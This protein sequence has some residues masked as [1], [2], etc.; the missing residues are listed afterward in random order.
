MYSYVTSTFCSRLRFFT[1]CV[2][3]LVG[4]VK[5][6]YGQRVYADAERNGTTGSGLTNSGSITDRTFSINT[7][8]S[9]FT[10][11]TATSTLGTST[12]WQQ[13]IFP[14]TRP[15]NSLI[16]LKFTS[17][18]ALLGGGVTT[19]AYV[20]SSSNSDGSAVPTQSSAF[21]SVDG[22]T[23]LAITSTS[24]FNA[25]R[26]TLSSPVALGTATANIY[27]AFYEPSNTDCADVIGTAVGGSGISL[28]G[29]VSS[30]S[31]AIDNDLTTFSTING[32]LL[33]VGNTITQTAY[34]SNLSNIGDAATV[35]FSVPPTLLQLGLFNNVVVKTYNG[36][37][38]TPV[39]TTSLSSLLS[40]DLLG[41]L[42]SG[43]RF[44]ASVTPNGRFDRIEVS[45]ATGVSLLSNFRIH[46]IQRTPAKPTTPTAYPNI[47]QICDGESATVTAQSPSSGSILRWYDA[48][49][50]G[51]L[52]QES[53]TNSN[54]YTTPPIFYS[55]PT[56]TTFIYVA[57]SW[58]SGCPAESERTK[59]AIVVRPK[60]IVDPIVGQNEVCVNSSITL[61]SN[62]VGG[63][64]SST[65][66]TIASVNVSSGM[67]TGVGTGTVT[68]RYTLS[69]S[70]TSCSNYQEKEI[71]V[72]PKPGRPDLHI[73]SNE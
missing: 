36:F 52:L 16:F 18:N 22:M 33:A 69:N 45:V 6:G 59:I 24:D 11:L 57:A 21:T 3:L 60:P 72:H 37:N 4:V 41:L 12:A 15:A 71:T 1:I 62:T 63:T 14:I 43:S 56:D 53:N 19:Q 28:G 7:N 38:P 13:L 17:S 54:T 32:G 55:S 35:T 25:V 44:T 68:I 67:V 34:F 46:E 5:E 2:V 47:I 58:N 30:P 48:V 29:G 66:N 40:L 65:D 70:Q 73:S 9:D 50:D 10:K 49:N 23:Y 27:Y 26:L 64:W 31:N 42:S 61:S 8:Y 39:S 51:T 20:N